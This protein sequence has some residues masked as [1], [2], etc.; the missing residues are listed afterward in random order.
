[1]VIKLEPDEVMALQKFKVVVDDL[2]EDDNV[3]I[4]FLRARD[5]DVPSAEKMLRNAVEWRKDIGIDN[6]LQWEFPPNY[7][8]DL[9]WKYFG[10]DND[11]AGICWMVAG[12]SNLK[13][14]LDRGEYDSALR[15]SFVM[16]ETGL[17]LFSES[18]IPGLVVI[19]MEDL[20][21]NKATHIPSL[22]I[23]YEGLQQFE[24]CYPE[25]ARRL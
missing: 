7:P 6:Y 13:A 15:W 25:M 3:L 22:K 19:D 16:M 8:S 20:S 21:Y 14:I 23:L 11:G 1:M 24:K 18:G 9:N 12:R 17:K 4:R 10:T 5:Y 2:D